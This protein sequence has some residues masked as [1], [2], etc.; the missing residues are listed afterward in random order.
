MA[1]LAGFVEKKTC[2]RG[3]LDNCLTTKNARHRDKNKDK[4]VNAKTINTRMN[5][6]KCLTLVL[7][8]DAI[9]CLVDRNRY[10]HATLFAMAK[11]ILPPYS[12]DS[13]L[14]TVKWALAKIHP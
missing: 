7:V 8:F 12:A 6:G 4:R 14:V 5:A 10:A 13:T 9:M 11:I 3:T 2:P 1:G